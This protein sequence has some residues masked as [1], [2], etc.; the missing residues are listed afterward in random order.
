MLCF[1]E[2][3]SL[4]LGLGARFR[5]LSRGAGDRSASPWASPRG[6]RAAGPGRCRASCLRVSPDEKNPL[7]LNLKEPAW[8]AR[9]SPFRTRFGFRSQGAR[10]SRLGCG[11]EA[12]RHLLR[13]PVGLGEI[14]VCFRETW[15]VLTRPGL[16]TLSPRNGNSDFGL[17]SSKIPFPCQAAWRLAPG[18]GALQGWARSESRLYRRLKLV[19][20]SGARGGGGRGWGI[21]SGATCERATRLRSCFALYRACV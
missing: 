7:S 4:D 2:G 14:W 5:F 15:R 21:N 18:C 3:I 19:W 8:A 17:S 11:E 1:P 16:Q 12:P 20:G 13:E 6:G 10:Q 9:V